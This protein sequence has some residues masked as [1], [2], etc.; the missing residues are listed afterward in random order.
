MRRL[1]DLKNRTGAQAG[2]KWRRSRTFGAD[3]RGIGEFRARLGD[4]WREMAQIGAGMA[5]GAWRGV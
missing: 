1:N 4:A 5:H 2:E 3:R